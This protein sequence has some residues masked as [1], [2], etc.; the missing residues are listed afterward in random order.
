M[1]SDDSLT[2]SH[3]INVRFHQLFTPTMV[4]CVVGFFVLGYLLRERLMIGFLT[5]PELNSTIFLVIFSAI[6]IAFANNYQLYKTLRF[7]KFIE[8]IEDEG[9]ERSEDL[10]VLGRKLLTDGAMLNIQNM[11]SALEN[12]SVYGHLNFTDHDAR[13]IKSKFGGRMRHDRNVVSYLSGILVMLGLIGTFWG[14]L[15][16]IDDVGKAMGSVSESLQVD[17]GAGGA[18]LG[19][20]IGSISAPL[21]GM[22]I[23]FSSSLFGLSGSLFLGFLNFFAGHAQN[24]F[25]EEVSRWIDIRIPK[26]N[27]AL[28]EK[29]KGQKV[30][31]SD[32]LKAWLA[33]FVYLSSKTNQKMGQIMLALSKS[34]E[35][36]LKSA[37]QTEKI[38]DY[39]KDIFM[40]MERMSTRMGVVKDSLQYMTKGVEPNLR[41]NAS[42]R[43]TLVEINTHL[44]TARSSDNDIALQQIDR[45]SKLTN[46]M[47]EVNST[48]Q[49]L[50]QVQSSLVVE[51]EK[52]RERS[53]KDDNVSEFSNLVWQLNSILEEIRQSNVSAYMGLFEDQG[54]H[55]KGQ[56]NGPG[57]G[58]VP[59]E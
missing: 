41:I 19:S 56:P 7:L 51:I 2:L 23:A 31:K 8:K 29:T 58:D 20:F 3:K 6:Y 33:G 5:A 22:G 4:M 54:P 57:A 49:V 35:A 10:Q 55:G 44:T 59:A 43:D 45:L 12:L 32:D 48:F 53:Q 11:V 42:I 15:G 9:D 24:N 38:Y 13:L 26:L 17:S 14:L 46:Q 50:S 52:L 18:D 36:M 34:T 16:A 39:Q 47:Q 37:S 25:V 21:Q 40:S 1:T 30:P 27:P 28:Q